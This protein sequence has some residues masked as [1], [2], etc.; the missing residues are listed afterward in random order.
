MKENILVEARVAMVLVRLSNEF[1]LQMCGEVYGIVESTTSI[2]VRE[3]C[4]AIRK[5]LKPLV[6][7]KLTRNKIKDFIIGF[8]RLHGIPYILGAIDGSHVPIITPKVNPKSYYY[9]KGFYSKLIQGL[10]DAKCSFWDYH[11]EWASSIHNW[12]LF[13]KIGLGN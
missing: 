2:I 11:Y 3:F 10:V 4:V 5:H 1:F 12:A 6:I 7:P 9:Q 8:E 13:Q